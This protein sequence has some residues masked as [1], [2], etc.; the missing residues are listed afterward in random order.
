MSEEKQRKEQGGRRISFSTAVPCIMFQ[1]SRPLS[2][3]C[4]LAATGVLLKLKILSSCR[5]KT[6]WGVAQGTVLAVVVTLT[7]SPGIRQPGH[8]PAWLRVPPAPSCLGAGHTVCHRGMRQHSVVT[9]SVPRTARASSAVLL[10][11]RWAVPHAATLSL[12]CNS[13]WTLLWRDWDEGWEPPT[14]ICPGAIVKNR[15]KIKIASKLVR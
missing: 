9:P 15:E 4:G 5:G 2:A 8:S 6:S 3:A 11:G 13:S 7:K 14:N 12:G 10:T 1:S